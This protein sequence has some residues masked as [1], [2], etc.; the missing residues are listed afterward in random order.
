MSDKVCKAWD[1]G[2]RNQS[3]ARELDFAPPV[4]KIKKSF[5]AKLR[6]RAP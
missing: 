6:P 3:D 4:P 5:S 1:S 2:I